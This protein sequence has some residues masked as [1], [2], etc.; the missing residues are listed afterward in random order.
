MIKRV[1]LIYLITFYF[2]F[3][4]LLQ[5]NKEKIEDLIPR[6]TEIPGWRIELS[7]KIYNSKNIHEYFKNEEQRK[8]FSTYGLKELCI[9]K[10][11]SFS[12]PT[13]EIKV[14]IFHMNSPLN[15]FGILS[16]G[17]ANLSK[18]EDICED[19]YSTAQGIF[20]RKGNYYI[21]IKSSTEYDNS[22]NDFKIFSN[23]VCD[24]IKNAFEPLPGY[25][26]LFGGDE[27]ISIKYQ[28]EGDTRIQSLKKIF[29]GN[30]GLFGAY[31]TIFFAKRDSSYISIGEFS[32][33]LKDGNNPYILSTAEKIQ[34]A[35]HKINYNEIIFISVYKE[36]IFGVLDAENM[37][38]GEKIINYMFNE[39]L[40]FLQK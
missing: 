16:M 34:T 27:R 18:K 37:V 36:W 2:S 35:F 39:L 19:S 7:P 31:R 25:I 4:A 33:L 8:L 40:N 6:E 32:N 20:L 11:K 26:S 28:I 29:T 24:K 13:K 1:L 10:F 21:R 9:A 22:L 12:S 5:P 23:I 14:E 30:L 3:C 38:E 17:R 15:A